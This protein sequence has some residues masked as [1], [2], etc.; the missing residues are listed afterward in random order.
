MKKEVRVFAPATVANIAC[1][2]D[3]MGFAIDEPGDE[4]VIRISGKPGVRIT[5]ISGDQ[6]RLPLDAALNT[7]GK[8]LLSMV[9][10]LGIKCGLEMEI[11]KKMPLGS[12]LG[13]SAASAVAAVFALDRL[14]ELDLPIKEL[15]NF[16][17]E[18]EQ[19]AS[20]SI[21][22]DNVAPCLYGGFVLIRS[23][24]PL[25]I[26]KLDVPEE[27]YCSVIHPQIEIST[28]ESRQILPSEISLS[29]AI[30]QW[31][32]TAALVA[33]LL[34]SDYNLI[35]RSL[36]DV[37]IEPVRSQLIPGFSDIKRAAI[38]NGA[39]G[40]SISGSGPSLFALS[41]GV[42][43]AQ[44]V[45]VAMQESLLKHQLKSELYVSKINQNGPRII[46]IN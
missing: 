1:G 29:K 5:N 26:I 45:G 33:G 2:F 46:E 42:E 27:L 24:E 10:K 4:V 18:G 17:I 16:A 30:K 15:L 35:G 37:V 28:K 36:E 38:G 40:C 13:S 25:D 39:L 3:I 21:H 31:G 19:L 12:G 14:L 44:K 8:P 43:T 7:A 20:G 34:K 32:N 9:K 22:A 6:G 41:K 11:H 23:Y